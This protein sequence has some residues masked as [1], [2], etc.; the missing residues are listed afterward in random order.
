MS[1]EKIHCKRET[2]RPLPEEVL[3][4]N[5]I[6]TI[7]KLDFSYDPILCLCHIELWADFTFLN[8]NKAFVKRQH[9]NNNI[10]EAI[11][12]RIEYLTLILMS[13]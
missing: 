11:K 9:S 10:V 2:G 5:D 6:N 8:P 1:L 13:I 4:S 7:R 12:H 3:S